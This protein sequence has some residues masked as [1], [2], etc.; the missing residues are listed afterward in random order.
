MFDATRKF[1]SAQF[2]TVVPLVVQCITLVFHFLWC[3]LFIDKLGWAEFGAAMATNITY[4]GNMIIIDIWCL[5]NP[6]IRKSWALP[7]W[8]MFNDLGEYLKISIPGAC[9]LCFEWWVFELLAIFCGLMSVEALA[10][11]VVI[12]NIVSFIFMMPLGTSYAAS[13]LTGVFLGE[14]KVPQAK[15]YARLTLVFNIFVTT[16][17]VIILGVFRRG[18]SN[19]F[20]HDDKTVFIIM[21]VLSI[22]LLYIFFDTIHGVQSGIIRGLGR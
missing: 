2:V 6:S 8:K 22:V 19:L 7:N 21:D 14:G 1:C 17:V 12:V 11:E 10:A 4:I 5:T 15:K 3:W 16:I 18:I 13:A 20:T 9:M